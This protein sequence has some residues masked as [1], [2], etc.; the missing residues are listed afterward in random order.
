[1]TS[2]QSVQRRPVRSARD[3]P[4]GPRG[5]GRSPPPGRSGQARRCRRRMAPRRQADRLAWAARMALPYS[6]RRPYVGF[7]ALGLRGGSTWCAIAVAALT[8]AWRSP[9]PDRFCRHSAP[10]PRRG[11]PARP[12]LRR[13]ARS[14]A[15]RQPTRRSWVVLSGRIAPADCSC[16]SAATVTIVTVEPGELVGWSA[17]RAAAPRHGRGG[18]HWRT[19]SCSSFD[20]HGLRASAARRPRSWPR[21]L[22]RPPSWQPVVATPPVPSWPAA[23]GRVLRPAAA[24]RPGDGATLAAACAERAA[25]PPARIP[26]SGRPRRPPRALRTDGRGARWPGRRRRRHRL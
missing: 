10:R 4:D 22:L 12:G 6:A 8:A 1:M 19:P 23:R 9:R 25:C 26:A 24:A 14:P 17:R 15:R 13:P 5:P 3:G 7:T 11:W 20:G 16:P 2:R 18:R 21:Q